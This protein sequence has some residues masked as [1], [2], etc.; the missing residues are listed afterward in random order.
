VEPLWLWIRQEK[1]YNFD[2]N[3][4]KEKKQEIF[5]FI[6]KI[7]LQPEQLKRRLVIQFQL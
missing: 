2:Y 4:F 7:S 5:S 1:T 6:E 3:T